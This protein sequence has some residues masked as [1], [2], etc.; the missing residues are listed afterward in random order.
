M[1]GAKIFLKLESLQLTGSFKPRISLS[2]LTKLSRSESQRGAIASTAGGHGIG[3]AYS[4]QILGVAVDIYLPRSVDQFKLAAIRR[5]GAKVTF[6][7]NVVEARIAA[8]HEAQETGKTFVSAYNDPD[9][10]SGSGTIGIE[11]VEDVGRVDYL[12][13]G[14]GGGGLLCGSTLAIRFANPNIKA[15]GVQ[16]EKSAVLAHWLAAGKPVPVATEASIADGLGAKV[17]EDTMTFPLLQELVERIVTVSEEE[18][19]SAMRWMLDEHQMVVE[20]S[21][22]APIAALQKLKFIADQTVVVIVTGRNISGDRFL[23]MV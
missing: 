10:I 18:I 14:I 1:T 3:L 22:A 16:P 19:R 8:L 5:Y 13:T 15:V 4:G 20:P 9:V 21:A 2:K 7:D 6:F 11:I 17:E 23:K 12:V